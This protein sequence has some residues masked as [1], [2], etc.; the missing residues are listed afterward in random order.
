MGFAD[1]G[2]TIGKVFVAV[3]DF[4]TK[5]LQWIIGAIKDIFNFIVD[6]KLRKWISG[7]TGLS[8]AKKRLRRDR[9][10]NYSRVCG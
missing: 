9:R 10:T 3:I 4:V 1:A 8:E 5:P 7:K 6:S 2:R